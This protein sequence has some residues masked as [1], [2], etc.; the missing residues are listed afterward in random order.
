[1][2]ESIIVDFVFLNKSSKRY[3]IL[4]DTKCPREKYMQGKGTE[5]YV[6]EGKR[7]Q[8]YIEWLGKMQSKQRV[9]GGEGV[10]LADIRKRID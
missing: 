8:F 6:S 5:G 9:E 7:V 4:E 1:M 2:P 3:S 10:K